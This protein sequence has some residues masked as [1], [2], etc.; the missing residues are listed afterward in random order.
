MEINKEEIKVIQ[1]WYTFCLINGHVLGEESK[2]LYDK[3]CLGE[4]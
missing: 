4:W 1:S 2:T 3:L